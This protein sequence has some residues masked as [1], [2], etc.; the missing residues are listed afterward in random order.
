[1][2][3]KYNQHQNTGYILIKNIKKC[4]KIELDFIIIKN[5]KKL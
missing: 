2:S 3:N 1:M 5:N 4:F